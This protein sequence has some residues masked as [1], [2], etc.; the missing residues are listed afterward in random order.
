MVSAKIV[1]KNKNLCHDCKKEIKIKSNGTLKG[2]EL[3]Y[4]DNGEKIAILKCNECFEKNPGLTNFRKCEVYSRIVGYL[5][6]IAQW[7][8]G[9][10]QE[11]KARKDYKI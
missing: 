4:E 9:K 6:P 5:R 3:V 10:K 1:K 2:K 11:Y 8:E 7:N